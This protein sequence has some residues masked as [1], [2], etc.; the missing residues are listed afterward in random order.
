MKEEWKMMDFEFCLDKT[1]TTTKLQSSKYGEQG[2]FPIVSQ[3]KELISGYWDNEDDVF[4]HETPIVI[5]GDHTQVVKYIDFD[6]VIGADGVK[7][8]APKSFFNP[9]YFYYWVMSVHIPSHGY[10]RHYRYLKEHQVPVPPLSEQ[11]RIVTLLDDEFAKIDALKANAERNLQNA[12]DLF[13]AALKKELSPKEGWKI[14]T[15]QQMLKLTSGDNLTTKNIVEGNY[16]VYGGN[17]IMGYHNRYNLDGENVIV[18]RVGAWCGNVRL[19][20]GK[21]WYTDNAFLVNDKTK[22]FYLPYLAY[23]LENANLRRCAT[24]AAQPV[25]SN[26]SIKD[27]VLSLPS[28]ILIQQSIVARL[29]ALND[30]CKALQA[31]YEKTIALCDDLKQALLRKAFNGET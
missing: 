22:S 18:G 2:A 26:V 11:Q 21:I 28:S 31:N 16:P 5:F 14:S 10:A 12:K 13:Q 1:K 24:Q 30:K 20:K 8:L 17:G 9:K 7:I 23:V 19:V 27:V 3:E 4:K 15:I 25:I 6:F 29:D